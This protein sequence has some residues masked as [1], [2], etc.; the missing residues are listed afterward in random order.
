M[1]HKI[2]FSENKVV[3]PNATGNYKEKKGGRKRLNITIRFIWCVISNHFTAVGFLII[4]A[5]VQEMKATVNCH[6]LNRDAEEG[7]LI[8]RRSKIKPVRL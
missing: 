4:V 2:S 3:E 1:Q 8:M 5:I 6:G 7:H